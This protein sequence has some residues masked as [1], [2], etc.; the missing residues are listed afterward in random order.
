HDAPSS[1]QVVQEMSGGPVVALDGVA[2]H[3]GYVDVAVRA[4]GG[5]AG[6]LQAAT[7]RQYEMIDQ[8][9]RRLVEAQDLS[10]TDG[11]REARAHQQG[12][13]QA[14]LQPFH[15]R[16]EAIRQ[17]PAGLPTAA[18]RST[19]RCSVQSAKPRGKAHR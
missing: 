19:L 5:A 9:A 18:G 11:S 17:P 6:V 8:S 10:G 3:V 12:R 7:P 4:E 14:D 13:R 16:A 1:D 2:L 15:G